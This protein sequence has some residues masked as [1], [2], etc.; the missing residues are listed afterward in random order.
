[1][2]N[3]YSIEERNR[4][5]DEHLWC[6][7]QVIRRNRALLHAAHLDEDDVRQQ[8]SLRLIRAV[9]G[10]DPEKGTLRQHIF[11]QL[12]FELLDCKRPYR[13]LGVTGLPA[14]DSESRIISLEAYLESGA[15]LS[16]EALVA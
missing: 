7:G 14:D 1:M 6:I 5:V 3:T 15:D 2:K 12:Q 13:R 9:A 4:I 10:F 8:L 16:T 11:A